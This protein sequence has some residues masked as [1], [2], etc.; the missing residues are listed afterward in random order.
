MVY[1]RGLP[2]DFDDWEAMGNPG[3]G[4]RDVLPFFR[5]TSM[6]VTDVSKY[7]HPL[8]ARYIEAARAMGFRHTDDFN[9]AQGEGV[10][11]Y[12]INTRNGIRSSSANEYLRPALGR[13]N[14]T[15]RTR[16][17]ASRLVFKDHRAVGVQYIQQGQQFEVAARK[18]VILCG[19]SI[20][21]PQLLQLSGIGDAEDLRALGIESIVEARPWG[22][23]C[24]TTS[25]YRISTAARSRP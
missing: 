8:C 22:A 20:N 15:L 19:G 2:H 14:L 3:W 17:H 18:Q 7:A 4:Y 12:Q 6:H 11:I 24:R 23:T 25:R 1:M 21:S 16:A 10:G 9:G 5:G 13:S